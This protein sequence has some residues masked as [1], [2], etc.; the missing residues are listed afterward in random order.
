MRPELD[1]EQE[2]AMRAPETRVLVLSGAGSGKT[3]LLTARVG[4]L[5]DEQGVPGPAIAC[6][7]FSKAAAE[8]MSYRLVGDTG[9]FP[10]EKVGPR[11]MWIGTIHSLGYRILGS[12][13]RGRT[14]ADKMMSHRLM[15][16]TLK[17]LRG[18]RDLKPADVL[19][20]LE[21]AK[22]SFV[23]WPA[24][25][26]VFCEK[27]QALLR[28]FRMFDFTDL[29]VEAVRVLE[30]K[31]EIRAQWERKFRHVL[32]DEVQDTSPVQW[33]LIRCLLTPATFLFAVGDLGQSIYAFRGARPEYLLDYLDRALGPWVTYPLT[34]NYRSVPEVIELA[35]RVSAGRRG[36]VEIKPTREQTRRPLTVRAVDLMHT[37][38]ADQEATW[39]V[40]TIAHTRTLWP[41]LELS[42]VAVLCRTNAQIE[43]WEAACVAQ[44]LP[45]AVLGGF[46][47]YQR[48]EVADVI[49]WMQ[50]A[51]AEAGDVLEAALDRVYN[52]PSRY[53]GKVWHEALMAQGGWQPFL[54]GE[55]YSWA[56]AYQGRNADAL[57]AA[58]HELRQLPLK[59]ASACDIVRHIVD[60]PL[61]YRRWVLK[62]GD[63][64]G[65]ITSDVDSLVSENLDAVLQGATRFP[66]LGDYLDFVDLC[67]VR[68]TRRTGGGVGRVVLSTIH[69]AKGLEWRC[70]YVAGLID[71]KLPH[72]LGHEDEER[73]LFYVAVTRAGDRLV[74]SAN[75]EPS[76]FLADLIGMPVL[77]DPGP[78]LLPPAAVAALPMPAQGLLTWDGDELDEWEDDDAAEAEHAAAPRDPDPARRPRSRRGR[79]NLRVVGGTAVGGGRASGDDS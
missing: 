7:T 21:A 41:E 69:R 12:V 76:R 3:R 52:R 10:D 45:Y 4:W 68:A 50:I 59:G 13:F 57:L 26:A 6:I 37:T 30:E 40:G 22:S 75:G 64:V 9:F 17:E 42:D 66:K 71:G 8:E 56:L 5:R 54:R 60:G 2:R 20:R 33:R 29:L 24:D 49:A 61:G 38:T 62:D 39:G 79:G 43:P 65:Q 51:F 18:P 19:K 63:T 74:L 78:E 1:A 14:V 47:F 36:M 27:Y 67:K 16:R 25:I 44:K 77:A 48:T 70:V 55:P 34:N 15:V 53:L 31:P 72:I 58:I 23:P 46:S 28:E 73:R 32:V 35:N 11:G